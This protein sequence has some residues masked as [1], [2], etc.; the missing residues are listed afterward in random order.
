MVVERGGRRPSSPAAVVAKIVLVVALGGAA[1]AVAL[2][3]LVG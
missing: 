2:A 3:Y 1:V